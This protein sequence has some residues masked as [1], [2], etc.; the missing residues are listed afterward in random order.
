[1]TAPAFRKVDIPYER[2]SEML[3]VD[4]WAFLNTPLKATEEEL[5]GVVPW[6]RA[7]GM[8]VVDPDLGE[9]GTLAAC[10]SSHPY[11][12]RVPGGGTVKTSG[13]TWVGVH[14]AYRRRGLLTQ[15]IDDHFERA[16]ARGE[17]VSTLYAAETAIYQRFGY[18]LACPMYTMT[19]GRGPAL[20]EVR[21]SDDL[22]L[23]L[24]NADITKHADV[25]LQVLG[26]I[27]RPGAHATVGE[28][29]MRDLFI[30]PEQWRDRAEQLRFATVFDSSGPAAFAIF[31]RKL[32]WDNGMPNGEFSMWT[33]AAATGA[34]ERRLLSVVLDLDL[35]AT[36][37]MR[38]IAPDSPVVQL[39][40]DVR[41]AKFAMRDNL[42]VRILDIPGA[43]A[44]RGYR[45]DADITIAVTDKQLPANEGLWRLR[46]AG[47]TAHA[48]KETSPSAL[49]DVTIS[50]QELS[51]AYLGGVTIRSLAAAGLVTGSADAVG[52]LSDAFAGTELPISPLNF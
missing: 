24:E 13:L 7:R 52:T 17:V 47:G 35:V 37:R 12:M 32:A 45:A 44:A 29:L 22:K 41:S 11:E 14:S 19:C 4:G 34:A 39:M 15:M 36:V 3:E 42:W 25:M 6:D 28:P 2:S 26:R 9:P 18:G 27:T 46:I 16:L 30:D 40:Q 33:W 8:E 23:T 38:N 31:N 50:I 49:A 20:R 48:T 1:M 10:H 43:L 21:G 5:K 51:A